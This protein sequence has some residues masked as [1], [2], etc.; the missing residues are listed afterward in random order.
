MNNKINNNYKMELDGLRA[1]AVLS[2]VIYHAELKYKGFSLLS[3]G[4]LGVDI[5]FVLS[6]FL[7][8]GI[9]INK[10]PTIFAFY[11]SRIDRIYP[12]LILM[13]FFSS[14]FA[15]KFLS[16]ND[17]LKFVESLKGALGF[18]SNYI[19]MNEDSYV[20]DESRYKALLHTWSLGVEW[21]YYLIFPFIIYT[22]KKFLSSKF[23]L[24]LIFLFVISFFYCLYLM[25]IN[26][27]YAFYSTFSRVWQLFSGG[28]IFLVSK[29]LK[30]S[31][32]DGFLSIFGLIIIIY[33]L[34]FFKDT[35][36]HPGFISLIV[37]FGTSLFILFT[38]TKTIVH[39]IVTLRISIFFGVISYSLYL[40]HQPILVFY[41]LA[42]GE[43]NTKSFILLGILMILLS[44]LSYRFFENPM[45][46]SKNNWKYFLV[47]IPIMLM[48]FFI[49]EVK[50]SN[51]FKKNQP[52]IMT[53]SLQHFEVVEFRRLHSN[54]AGT[55][56]DGKETFICHNRMPDSS[57]KI[58]LEDNNSLI[59]LGD[60]YAGVF[61]YILSK[62]ENLTTYIF[63][64]EQCPILNDDIWFGNVPECWDI[65]KLRWEELSKMKPTSVLIGTNF[66]QFYKGK[67]VINTYIPMVTKDFKERVSSELVYE[68]FRKSIEKLISLGHKP[69]VVLQPPIPNKDIAK[70][71]KRKISSGVQNFK[72]E[73][74]GISTVNIDND[75]RKVLEGIE[76]VQF[77]DIN[78][79][80]CN[81]DNE[82]LTFNKNGGLYNNGSHLS[83][84]G[85]ELFTEDIL[86]ILK[87]N[88]NLFNKKVETK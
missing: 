9:L 35:D 62:N 55:T 61:S 64:Y 7:I 83:Y 37:V 49:N 77:I 86:E 71:M 70:E 68:S 69:I 27:T 39:N 22:I 87:A 3:G 46:K 4:F 75:V 6:G 16:P 88:Q 21:Q 56:I 31:S 8:T 33:C 45:R 59:I 84:F 85:V 11:K 78:K 57:C 41:R 25:Q 81:K 17:L 43:V 32:Y 58:G 66:N 42:Y 18:Y 63:E 72:D 76:E 52:D 48:F 19:F 38:K 60:S 47:F 36:N 30:D 65:N 79:K 80:M 23:E 20:A 2:V 24:I 82:C 14:I 53:K 12:A 34:L 44:Y 26:S 67:K 1:I 54:I 5:F 73:F 10:N 74:Q 51:G 15:Y 29:K 50:D 40:F 28:I 13:L